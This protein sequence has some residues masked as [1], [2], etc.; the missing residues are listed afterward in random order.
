MTITIL[1]FSL[2]HT[3]THTNAHPL[4]WEMESHQELP[5]SPFFFLLAQREIWEECALN[6]KVGG[7]IV[8]FIKAAV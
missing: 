3:L 6:C 4:A 5:P 7:L 8:F 1:S 2:T